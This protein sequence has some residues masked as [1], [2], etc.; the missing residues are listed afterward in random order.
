MLKL[1]FNRPIPFFYFLVILSIFSVIK[2]FN[3]PVALYPS[4]TMPTVVVSSWGGELNNQ[5]YYD[6][7]GKTFEQQF[8]GN[9]KITS[10]ESSYFSDYRRWTIQF[11]WNTSPEE[12]KEEIES[13]V[14]KVKPSLPEELQN[15]FVRLQGGRSSRLLV[16]LNS[17][18]IS[19]SDLSKFVKSNIQGKLE[20]LKGAGDVWITSDNEKSIEVIVDYKKLLQFNLTPLDVKKT[21]SFKNKIISLGT[22]KKEGS[23]VSK[24]YRIYS[25]INS[26]ADIEN[27][28][29][30]NSGR[31]QIFLK[32]I[33]RVVETKKPADRI[34][35]GNGKRGL[36]ISAS[37]VEGANISEF[38]NEAISIIK[39]QL[40]EIKNVNILI[41]TNPSEFIESAIKNIS[42]SLIIGVLV[43]V[44]VVFLFFKSFL[45]TFVIGS[46]IPLSL[47][48]GIVLMGVSGVELNL[49]S[50]G[51]MALSVGMVVDGAVVVF[52]NIMAKKEA[53]GNEYSSF[54]SLIIDATQQVISPVVASIITTLVVFLPL[55]FTAPMAKAILGDLASVITLVMLFSIFISC[56]YVPAITYFIY[57]GKN[58]VN[59]KPKVSRFD[60]FFTLLKEIYLKK[61]SALLG[62][63]TRRVF[64]V[65]ATTLLFVCGVVIL[66]FVIEKEVIPTPKSDTIIISMVN[67]TG[68]TEVE[69]LD[70]KIIP[71]ENKVKEVV[72][73]DLA[74]FQTIVS[75]NWNG[76]FVKLN[77]A[78]Q[79]DQYLEKL[80][81]SFQT[82][83]DF[84]FN[85]KPWNPTQLKIP[86]PPKMQVNFSESFT[87]E[88]VEVIEKNLS[89]VFKSDKGISISNT[90]STVKNIVYDLEYNNNFK[91]LSHV[92]KE[93]I[94]NLIPII[95]NG[96]TSN[97]SHASVLL[98]G[99]EMDVRSSYEET[100]KS[101]FDFGDLSIKIGDR[102]VPLRNYVVFNETEVSGGLFYKDSKKSNQLVI[103]FPSSLSFNYIKEKIQRS[104]GEK[105]NL[106]SFVDGQ[107][108]INNNLTSLY[109]ALAVSLALVLF[110][111]LIQFSL[112]VDAFIVLSAI[113]LGTFAVAVALWAFDQTLSMNSLLGII[114]LS[115]IAVNNS[116]LFLDS[117][118]QEFKQES[119]VLRSILNTADSRFRPIIITTLTTMI[120]MLPIAIGLG[121]GGDV[122]KSLGIS[123]LVGLGWSTLST[124]FVVPLILQLSYKNKGGD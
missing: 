122:L 5:I 119:D 91:M 103:D 34:Y 88:D 38:C 65:I 15:I 78:N 106:V 33:A 123:V 31:E 98:N 70:K 51:A 73:E 86:D 12:A 27:L 44:F 80:N 20:G 90:T 75:D 117:F 115:G 112:L 59:S 16:S 52:E 94:K 1:I 121:N 29:V 92:N 8:E 96:F 2:F 79:M 104:L 62:S 57:R 95:F 35:K 93:K 22:L 25:D 6:T 124:I 13:I 9:S 10:V 26:L 4:V 72:G 81:E 74:S 107:V 58:I 87:Y 110:V 83:L 97:S 89:E 63:K 24:T 47:A 21:L 101:R 67:K 43:S 42:I 54:K 84:S 46:S 55:M 49:I 40:K 14:N 18:S 116:I 28:W 66:I 48:G 53:S 102:F 111:I 56:F 118:K 68:I 82:N 77:S 76:L 32:N 45:A 39:D 17:E 85:V 114:L 109:V 64:L 3:L 7:Y 50:L 108:E 30:A 69:R 11:D 37:P 120:G 60:N 41:L 71:F 36:I 113:P 99:Q 23:D 19:E 105:G 100:N 61:L